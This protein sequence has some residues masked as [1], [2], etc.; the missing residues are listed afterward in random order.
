MSNNDPSEPIPENV[1]P[2]TL[3]EIWYLVL[4]C[5]T[6]LFAHSQLER[7]GLMETGSPAAEPIEANY[8]QFGAMHLLAML[9]V[10][11]STQA[12]TKG[13]VHIAL[14]SLQRT[15]LLRDLHEILSTPI[16]AD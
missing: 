13:Y 7:L 1:S 2:P 11:D 9:C 12:S 5:R 8:H 15:D 10:T 3:D 14:E 4:H 6:F 16:Y